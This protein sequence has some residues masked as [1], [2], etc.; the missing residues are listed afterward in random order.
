[1]LEP[2]QSAESNPGAAAA[3]RLAEEVR[4][5]RIAA[6]SSSII[7]A[8]VTLRDGHS[9]EPCFF[10]ANGGCARIFGYRVDEIVGSPV[11]IFDGPLTDRLSIEKWRAASRG[12]E[13]ATFDVQLYRRDGTPVWIELR[14]QHVLLPDSHGPVFVAVGRDVTEIRRAKEQIDRLIRIDPLTG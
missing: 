13:A 6:D 7:F 1:M 10:Y 4:Y 11:T 14:I 9:G 5:L 8:V 2:L 12:S 3:E